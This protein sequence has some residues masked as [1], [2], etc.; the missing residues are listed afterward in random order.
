M[1]ADRSGSDSDDVW[2]I[3]VGLHVLLKTVKGNT[4]KTNGS[5]TVD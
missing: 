3:Q 4:S 2:P 1:D 5:H